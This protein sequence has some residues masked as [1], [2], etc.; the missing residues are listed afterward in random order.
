MTLR[1]PIHLPPSPPFCRPSSGSLNILRS[2]LFAIYTCPVL[3][4]STLK[5]VA[6]PLHLIHSPAQ[7][8][9]APM[10]HARTLR[11]SRAAL[12]HHICTLAPHALRPRITYAPSRI[13]RCT[14]ASCISPTLAPTTWAQ[15]YT[16]QVGVSGAQTPS[17]TGL[18]GELEASFELLP[19]WDPQLTSPAGSSGL[20]P[21]PRRFA[22]PC[23]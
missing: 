7:L 12:T 9:H 3:L 15:Q 4:F 19:A 10:H 22:P 5:C 11:A 16:Q 20:G 18:R 2:L 23:T 13:M 8:A 17:N 14:H 21:R 1:R 6:P